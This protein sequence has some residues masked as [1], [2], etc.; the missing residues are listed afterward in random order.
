MI[1]IYFLFLN[2]STG[3]HRFLP[4]S[5]SLDQCCCPFLFCFCLRLSSFCTMISQVIPFHQCVF[6]SAA[7][8]ISFGGLT[9]FLD[10]S[11]ACRSFCA[12]SAVF[13]LLVAQLQSLNEGSGIPSPGVL[14]LLSLFRGHRMLWPFY[15]MVRVSR[16]IALC[17]FIL[18]KFLRGANPFDLDKESR[19]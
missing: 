1:W 19:P 15:R 3:T 16:S 2:R 12:W 17:Y 6:L 7:F 18:E 11:R 5:A 8:P 4:A 14:Y 10:V 9:P 13:A